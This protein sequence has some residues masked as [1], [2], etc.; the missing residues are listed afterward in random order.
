MKNEFQKYKQLKVAQHCTFTVRALKI[1]QKIFRVF[2][3]LNI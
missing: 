1:Q 3:V 2:I